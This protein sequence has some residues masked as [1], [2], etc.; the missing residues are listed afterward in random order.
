ML[1]AVYSKSL[2]YRSPALTNIYVQK[3]YGMYNYEVLG[4]K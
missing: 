4:T 2:L 3:A 1:P